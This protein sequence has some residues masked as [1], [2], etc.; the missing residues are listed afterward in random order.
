LGKNKDNE[1]MQA[2]ETCIDE[3]LIDEVHWVIK[4]GKEATVYLCE[5]SHETGSELVAAKVYRSTEVRRFA[6]D[7]TYRAGRMHGKEHKQEARAVKRKNRIGREMSFKSWVSDEFTTLNLLHARGADVPLPIA[8]RG[9]II[10]ME[11]IGDDGD[12][13]PVLAHA[14]LQ[15]DVA[16]PLFRRLIW[17]VRLMLA[18][19]RVHGDLSPFNVLYQRGAIRLIDFPQAVDARFN[20]NALDLLDRDIDRICAYFSRHGVEADAHRISRDMWQRFLRAD[21]DAGPAPPV[22]DPA[23]VVL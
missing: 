22:R 3:G 6:N 13:A 11:Y 10:L 20:P 18:C 2:L 16:E 15:P 1:Q 4:S 5:R 7:A 19:D 21:L 17:N 14:D 8:H 9:S 23:T 12:P